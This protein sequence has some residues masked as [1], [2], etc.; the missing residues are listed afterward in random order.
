VLTVLVLAAAACTEAESS[1]GSPASCSGKK[2]PYSRG[3][4]R[5]GRPVRVHA[6]NGP[7]LTTELYFPASLRAY[8]MDV[9][10]LNRRA[11][12]FKQAL[13]VRL[14]PRRGNDYRASFDFVI[15]VR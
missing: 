9:G 7:V 2:T 4:N 1:T 10:R 11:R 15:A 5:R 14:G 12:S 8:G 13:T 3:D 6:A